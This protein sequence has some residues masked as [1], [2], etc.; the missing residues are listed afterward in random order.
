MM[1][2][3]GV[4]MVNGCASFVNGAALVTEFVTFLTSAPPVSGAIWTR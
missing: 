1:Y 3:P 2:V 4:A